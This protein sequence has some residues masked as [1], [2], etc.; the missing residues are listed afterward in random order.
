MS[1]KEAGELTDEEFFTQRQEQIKKMECEMEMYPHK[2]EV[3][4]KFFDLIKKASDCESGQRDH[5]VVQSAGRIVTIRKHG[6]L[7]FFVIE[8]DSLS[9]QLVISNPNEE[10]TKVA[11]FVRRGDIVGF[12]GVCGKSKTG[13]N[14]V[15]LDEMKVLS[16]CL[17]V[18]PSLKSG[19]KDAETI[20]RKRHID[21]LVNKDSKE[22]F[23]NRIKIIQI[24]RDFFNS[25]DFLE[26]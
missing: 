12:R 13:E 25:K 3:T 19:L 18:V 17:R 14:S 2:Y 24:V 1:Q 15:F 8:S 4:H 5:E 7:Y 26:V 22:R 21:L 10:L 9:I 23:I 11:E 6:K 16:P 20:Y